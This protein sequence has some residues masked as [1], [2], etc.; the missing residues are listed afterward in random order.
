MKTSELVFDY[1]AELI[2]TE[3]KHP[4]RVLSYQHNL[5]AE[6]SWPSFLLEFKEGDVL[7]INDTKVLKRRVF[8]LEGHEVLFLNPANTDLGSP[9]EDNSNRHSK[10]SVLFPSK[11]LKIGDS[12][13]LPLGLK[14]E[15]VEKGIPQIIKLSEPVDE[16]FFD[17]IGELP[18]P[19]YIQKA[20]NERHNRA[21]EKESYQ[22]SWAEKPGSLAAPTASLHFTTQDLDFLKSRGVD[23][24]NITLHVGLGTFLPV[25]TENLIDH[26]M[27]AET[28]EILKSHW[29]KIL[30]AKTKG[31]SIWTLGTTVVRSLESQ[32]LGR[33][34]LLN[35][36][37]AGTTDLMIRPGFQFQI[38][39]KLLTN[40]HQPQSTLLALVMAFAG[41]DTVLKSYRWAIEKR[42]RL[43]SYGDLSYWSQNS[44]KNLAKESK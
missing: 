18:V 11:K 20:R 36:T 34:E 30:K 5:L 8:S 24:L 4:S 22:T 6:L 38:V 39:D 21:T 31:A 42:F 1:P 41:K 17:Q 25:T 3:P 35:D 14:A 23:V 10:W 44:E 19:P 26:K 43:F 32:A 9:V 37:Y 7:V 28:V 29:E 27:H 2:A 33:F 13:S 12:I 40:F 15:L 16:T